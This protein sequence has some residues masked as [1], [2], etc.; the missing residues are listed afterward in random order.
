MQPDYFAKYSSVY[1]SPYLSLQRDMGFVVVKPIS[2]TI[3]NPYPVKKKPISFFLYL[4]KT[5]IFA[6]SF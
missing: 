6:R 3:Q 4:L 2:Y 5:I 1:F